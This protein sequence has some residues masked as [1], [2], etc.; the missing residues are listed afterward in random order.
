MYHVWKEC[1]KQRQWDEMLLTILVNSILVG[2]TLIN[3]EIHNKSLSS[4][5]EYLGAS[6]FNDFSLLETLTSTQAVGLC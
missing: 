6:Y 1:I 4:A 2:F 5:K 3:N